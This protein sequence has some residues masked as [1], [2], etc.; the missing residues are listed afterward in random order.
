MHGACYSCMMAP[1]VAPLS[2]LRSIKGS[3][4]TLFRGRVD[5]WL[6]ELSTSY[7]LS[8]PLLSLS[9]RALPTPLTSLQL[10]KGPPVCRLSYRELQQPAAGY[11]NASFALKLSK[12]SF[13]TVFCGYVDEW[14]GEMAEILV[15]GNLNH[16][17]QKKLLGYCIE[18]D[19]LGKGPPVCRFS[20][21]ELQQPA[22][23]YLNASFAL[24]LSKGSFRTVFRGYV[25]EWLG[26]M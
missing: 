1:S 3:F 19:R 17:N 4:R 18:D 10:G 20:Y 8:P 2:A 13:R 12:G 15:L 23:G 16:P 25:D 24:K 9:S 26:E 14:L 22:A 5:E 21:R 7:L 11:F 6:G